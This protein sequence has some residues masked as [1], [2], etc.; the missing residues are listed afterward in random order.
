MKKLLVI[1]ITVAAF[2]LT[3]TGFAMAKEQATCPIMGGKINKE[4]FTDHAGKRV[5]FCCAGCIDSFKKDPEK[6]IK[7]MESEGVELAK[8]PAAKEPVAKEQKKGH[9]GHNH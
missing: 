1:M 7:K 4:V 3:I 6:H 5:Y 8:V 9:E 2:S